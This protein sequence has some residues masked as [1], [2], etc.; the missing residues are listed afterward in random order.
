M[1]LHVLMRLG[2]SVTLCKFWP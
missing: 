1:I 2:I